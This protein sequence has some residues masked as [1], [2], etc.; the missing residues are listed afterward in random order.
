MRG[1]GTQQFRGRRRRELRKGLDK[2]RNMIQA[3]E[4]IESFNNL[5]NFY[6]WDNIDKPKFGVIQKI[7]YIIIH[8]KFPEPQNPNEFREKFLNWFNEVFKDDNI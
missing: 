2:T 1:K 3:N 8:V 6:H 5:V 4:L 7:N